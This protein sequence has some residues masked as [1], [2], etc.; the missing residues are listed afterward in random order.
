MEANAQSINIA[1]AKVSA[2]MASH[3]LRSALDAFTLWVMCTMKLVLTFCA[4]DAEQV[5]STLC[6][7]IRR[8]VISNS[9]RIYHC[10]LVFTPAVWFGRLHHARHDIPTPAT[11]RR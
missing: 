3:I 4:G 11:H 10:Q 5:I 8:L 7:L 2:E 9:A 6:Y 1:E